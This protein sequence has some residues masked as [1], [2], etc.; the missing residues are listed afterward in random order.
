MSPAPTDAPALTLTSLTTPSFSAFTAFSIFIASSKTTV[1][2]T[3]TLSPTATRT[4]TMVPCIGT[5]TSPEP[6]APAAACAARL[7]RTTPW[8]AATA[9]RSGTQSFTEK[10]RPSTS[11]VTS[12]CTIGSASSAG[13]AASGGATV[14]SLRSSTSSTHLVEC[15]PAAKS[16]WLKM[17]TSAG[18]VV[19]IP[20]ISVSSRARSM[21]RRADSRSG[22]HTTSL[23]TRLS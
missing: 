11:A 19:A 16:G 1:C 3:S 13:G 15:V 20:V 12:R 21:R 9:T 7:G 5:A 23:A 4:L 14:S 18:M 2:P 8:G 17:A 22:A 6:V 10:R